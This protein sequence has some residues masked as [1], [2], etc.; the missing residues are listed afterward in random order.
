MRRIREIL[1][2]QKNQT[3]AF[4]MLDIDNFK[5]LNDTHGHQAGDRYLVE[6]ADILRS[7]F[8]EDDVVGRIGGDE[9]FILMKNIRFAYGMQ[10]S[11]EAYGESLCS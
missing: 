8:R 1:T 9:F 6:F 10:Q 4:F 5:L 2:A 3:H 7:S 11:A